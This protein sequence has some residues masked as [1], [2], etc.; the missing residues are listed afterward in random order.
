LE[1]MHAE[2]KITHYACCPEPY[3][4][5][6]F[7]FVIRRQPLM[8]TCGIILPMVLV[9]CMGFLAFMLN[10]SSG[11]RIGL[12]I[13]VMLTTVAVYLVANEAIPPIDTY[14]VV[15]HLY[16]MSLIENAFVMLVSI[17]VVSLHNVRNSEGLESEAALLAIFVKA[18][19]NNTGLLNVLELQT[20]VR[21][22]GLTPERM[23][24]VFKHIEENSSH[25]ISFHEWYD[26]VR[27]V[28][29]PDGLSSTH[30]FLYA[31]LI[32]PFLACERRLR[33]AVILR[34]YTENAE[35]KKE[36]ERIAS[37]EILL[38]RVALSGVS[39]GAKAEVNKQ[40]VAAETIV[41]ADMAADTIVPLGEGVDIEDCQPLFPKK[42][43]KLVTKVEII[44]EREI[45]DPT[46]IV[47]RRASGLIDQTMSILVPIAYLL[48]VTVAL[49]GHDIWTLPFHEPF[50]SFVDHNH[51]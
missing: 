21:N 22:I 41:S 13:T 5:L 14:T 33:K 18:D 38:P 8:Y 24:E 51:A 35:L 10:P 12:S 39:I 20:F 31:L 42:Q 1:S 36:I 47:A 49:S 30:C 17:F 7:T 6:S 3:P 2:R 50:T 48:I 44:T 16:L 43:K 4:I 23:E 19:G 32:R 25:T 26:I 15:T 34:R 45:A 11:E 40:D 29:V 28:A 37:R 46:E 9:T 27:K